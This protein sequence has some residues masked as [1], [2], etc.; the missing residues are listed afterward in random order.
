ML[1]IFP[2]V[3]SVM[4][5]P[6]C[7]VRRADKCGLPN[8]Q[9]NRPDD[10]LPSREL[11]PLATQSIDPLAANMI[12]TGVAS[13][14][15]AR[16]RISGDADRRRTQ[17]RSIQAGEGSCK[18][19]AADF[20]GPAPDLV[21][22]GHRLIRAR[23]A[24]RR[25]YSPDWPLDLRR[26]FMAPLAGNGTADAQGQPIALVADLDK[27]AQVKRYARLATRD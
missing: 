19:A 18:A 3:D 22:P 21:R 16:R 20:V 27:V 5:S 1:F 24:S 25:G 10:W 12:V 9:V 13:R 8:Q 4:A 14:P 11:L 15:S 7:A 23:P 17:V 2:A 6:C 26:L